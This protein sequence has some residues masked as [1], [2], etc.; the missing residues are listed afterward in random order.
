MVELRPPSYPE[1]PAFEAWEETA[2]YVPAVFS[3]AQAIT[4]ARGCNWR[5]RDDYTRRELRVRR[6]YMRPIVGDEAEEFFEGEFDSGWVEVPHRPLNAAQRANLTPMWKV[7]P[8][9]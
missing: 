4:E 8:R 5:L 2:A 6:V 9:A 1:P 3:R 7:E